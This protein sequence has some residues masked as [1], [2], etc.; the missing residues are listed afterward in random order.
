[1]VNG[2]KTNIPS[3]SVRVGDVI[4]VRPE[5]KKRT[6]FKHL[7]EN[8]ELKQHRAPEWLH[9][10][11]AEL[12]GEVKILPSRQDAELNINEQLIVEF[13]SR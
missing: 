10:N 3:F 13:Y 6:Y 1:M 7:G 2:R 4:T 9:L 5:S 11:P 12:S 8:G